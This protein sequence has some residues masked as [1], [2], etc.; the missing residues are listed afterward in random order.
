MDAHFV[1]PNTVTE[2]GSE[3]IAGTYDVM[4]M[5]DKDLVAEYTFRITR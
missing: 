1:S 3:P 2:F 4:L 5:L